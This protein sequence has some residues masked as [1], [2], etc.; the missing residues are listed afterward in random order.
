[1]LILEGKQGIGKSSA[2][3]ALAGEGFFCDGLIDF[4]NKDAC[5]NIQGVWI[6]ELAELDALL[7]GDSASTK[8]FLTRAADKFRAPYARS[9]QT[10]PRS[11]VF[12]GTINHGSYLK[13]QTGNRRF[14]VVRCEDTIN[15]DGIR[16]VREQLWAEARALYERREPWHLT[17]EEEALMRDQH[18]DRLESEPWEERIAEW[19]DKQGDAP[20]AIEHLLESALGLKAASRNPNVTQRVSHI[21]ERLGFERRRGSFDR[22]ARRVYRYVRVE[23]CPAGALPYCPS[24]E[25]EPPPTTTE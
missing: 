3:A 4:G 20:I 24:V 17:A 19:V 13:D 8:A 18:A 9:P 10:V 14:W 5:Q 15:V 12:C 7:R 6:Y 2:L 11:V 25:P 23:A 21:L 1:M 22:S 16:A